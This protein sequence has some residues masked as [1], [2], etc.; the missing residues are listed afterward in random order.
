MFV[1]TGKELIEICNQQNISI[2]EYTIIQEIEKITEPGDIVLVFYESLSMLRLY[3][4]EDDGTVTLKSESSV[5]D[6]ENFTSEE[7]SIIG[8]VEG[9]YTKF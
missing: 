2:W 4:P 5:I 9:R 3:Y 8:K 6:K 7:V 1:S